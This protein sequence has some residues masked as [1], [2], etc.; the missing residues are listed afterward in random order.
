[1]PHK[2]TKTDSMM[3]VGKPPWHGLGTKLDNVATAREALEAANLTWKVVTEPVVTKSGITLD[4]HRITVRE[5]TGAPLG[6]VGSRYQVIQATDAFAF[7]D[8]VTLDPNGPKYVTAGSLMGGKMIWILA[9]TKNVIE[10]VQGDPIEEYL[11]FT[12]SHDGS[13]PMGMK[14]TPIRVVCWNTLSAA[15]LNW[16]AQAQAGRAVRFR[17]TR[18]VMNRVKEARDI[19]GIVDSNRLLLQEAIDM[20]VHRQVT[21]E[22]VDAVIEALLPTPPPDKRQTATLNSRNEIRRLFVEGKGNENREIRGTA[23]ALYNGITEWSDHI[24]TSRTQAGKDP[25]ESRMNSVMFGAIA[26]A[27]DEAFCNIMALVTG[28]KTAA[29]IR[30]EGKISQTLI[31]SINDGSPD[32]D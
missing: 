9:K 25:R 2:I 32:I 10:V 18:N 15:L 24:R 22:E 26:K 31:D 11:L 5:D 16:K 30:E 28:T 19:L 6:V 12:N 13:E 21:Q 3:Y 17:H 14:Y 20:M 23:W 27:K 29:E 4:T 8:A 1:M 7:F